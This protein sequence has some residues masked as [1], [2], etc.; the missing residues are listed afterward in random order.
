ML[1]VT[2]Y[3][4]KHVNYFYTTKYNPFYN[5]NVFSVKITLQKT[6]MVDIGLDITLMNNSEKGCSLS[7]ARTGKYEPQFSEAVHQW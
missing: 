5:T 1:K 6:K 7:L 3:K 4:V 2:A